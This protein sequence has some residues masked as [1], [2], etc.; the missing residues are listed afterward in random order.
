VD[1]PRRVISR[2]VQRDVS[3][4]HARRVVSDIELVGAQ[5]RPDHQPGACEQHERKR[6]LEHDQRVTEPTLQARRCIDAI[7]ERCPH[8]APRRL[9]S[10]RQSA[11]YGGRKRHAEAE[12][13]HPPVD[14][15]L[16]PVRGLYLEG[17]H[18]PARRPPGEQHSENAAHGREDET[19]GPDQPR[20][21]RPARTQGQPD[22]NLAA[23]FDRPREQ[24]IGDIG[25]GDQK[26]ESHS[27]QKDQRRL[28]RLPP[29]G[30]REGT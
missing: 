19:L 30:P 14:P 6:E 21:P 27:R 16:D 1:G 12:H 15:E 2:L 23:P 9:H 11:D 3:D 5:N 22:R 7:L 13:R 17:G 4:Q 20:D 29:S 25:A 18:E 24:K 8:V 26:H 28:R 10:R